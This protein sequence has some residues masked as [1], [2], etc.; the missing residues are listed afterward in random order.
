MNKNHVIEAVDCNSSKTDPHSPGIK[1]QVHKIRTK[2]ADVSLSGTL[3][4]KK[5]DGM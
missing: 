5:G 4:L 1:L 2:I 3:T